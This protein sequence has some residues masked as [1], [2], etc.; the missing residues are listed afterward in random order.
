M[1]DSARYTFNMAGI[2][3][4]PGEKRVLLRAVQG[5]W[6]L[7]QVEWQADEYSSWKEVARF[8]R[9]MQ[10]LLDVCLSTVRCLGED[11]E[12]ATMHFSRIY[13]MELHSSYDNLPADA[14]W[15][16]IE[17]LK[18][19]MI[20]PEEHLVWLE[21]WLAKR[22]EE[23]R[24][25][26][27]HPDWLAKAKVWI[28]QALAEPEAQPLVSIEQVGVAERGCLLRVQ[29]KENAFYFKALP[30]FFRHELTLLQHLARYRVGC[31]PALVAV[32]EREHRLLMHD[33]G[34]K[35]LDQSLDL[36]DWQ[37]ALRRYAILQIDHIQI[38]HI[39][40]DHSAQVEQLEELGC[41]RLPLA[42][43]PDQLERLLTSEQSLL[44][45]TPTA[46]S[47]EQVRRLHDALPLIRSLC[48]E[49][50]GYGLPETLEHGDL[51]AQNIAL[52]G[53]DYL[54][55]DWTDSCIAHPFFSLYPFLLDI[56][57]RWPEARIRLREAYLQPWERYA[58][59]AQLV[60]AFELAQRLAPLHLAMLYATLII[61]HMKARW[62][63]QH[64]VPLNLK[65]LLDRLHDAG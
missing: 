52:S 36:A 40:I 3:M 21:E 5:G 10:G 13:V 18:E 45:D 29:T 41:P 43:L 42:T 26:W 2:I 15:I 55:F 38:D 6:M 4:H 30:A 16:D 48:Q 35:H 37:E 59:R 57:A 64:G 63:M 20:T 28:E 34:S 56:E 9:E 32:D 19:F 17:D 44:F 14:C 58:A 33:F 47:L 24:T 22:D 54:Y 61:P 60:E 8:N 23:E 46:L 11:F 65:V 27:Y 53:G 62:E 39:Q 51:H 50:A 49:L 25:P 7:P 1:A 31:V 12:R